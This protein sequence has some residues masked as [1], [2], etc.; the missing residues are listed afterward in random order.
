MCHSF[1]S[2]RQGTWSYVWDE[3]SNK[4]GKEEGR[5]R[6]SLKSKYAYSCMVMCRMD[7]Y[8]VD[9]THGAPPKTLLF[10]P[11][12]PVRAKGIVLPRPLVSRSCPSFIHD[13]LASARRRSTPLREKR[14][15]LLNLFFLF[16]CYDRWTTLLTTRLFLCFRIIATGSAIIYNMSY[17]RG[18]WHVRTYFRNRSN[19]LLTR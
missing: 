7:F 13:L 2:G 15:S 10:L 4:K 12:D 8:F 17:K 3:Y 9:Y 19:K 5:R 14:K 11:F 16:S 1:V 6:N 18:A